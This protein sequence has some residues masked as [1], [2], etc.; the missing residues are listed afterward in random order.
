M[1]KEINMTDRCDPISGDMIAYGL[2]ER[3]QML[4]AEN[5][6]LRKA[7]TEARGLFE[8]IGPTKDDEA[9]NTASRGVFITAKA[10]T[11]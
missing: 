9:S 1:A 8:K 3:V 2:R 5:E 7:L 11:A 4:E 10:L 6:R